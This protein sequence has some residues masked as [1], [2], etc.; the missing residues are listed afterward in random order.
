M[1]KSTAI[2]LTYQF[3]LYS[4]NIAK[5]VVDGIRIYFDFT[6]PTLLL[7]NFE[8]E[9]YR[10]VMGLSSETPLPLMQSA[11]KT[12]TTER[13]NTDG[14]VSS[15]TESTAAKTEVVVPPR[16]TET[17]EDE[18]EYCLMA[19]LWYHYSSIQ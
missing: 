18:G 12:E 15:S 5:E 11:E 8:R 1:Q 14:M 10:S 6:L 4:K 9:Q 19:V 13:D 17:R 7:Y 3:Q 2:W 16:Q